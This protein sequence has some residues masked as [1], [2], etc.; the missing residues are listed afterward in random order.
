[1]STTQT[2]QGNH[3]NNSHFKRGHKRQEM[4]ERADYKKECVSWCAA[5]KNM[6]LCFKCDQCRPILL[7]TA[8]QHRKT[9]FKRKESVYIKSVKKES[10][11]QYDCSKL[12]K[13]KEIKSSRLL[14]VKA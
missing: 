9:A 8:E 2:L 10:T 3:Y 5:K 11:Y 13:R 12:F 4:V 14:K 7:L 1:M 6:L